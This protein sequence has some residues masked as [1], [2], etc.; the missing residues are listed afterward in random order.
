MTYPAFE[1]GE[2]ISFEYVWKREY[3]AGQRHGLKARPCAVVV[4]VADA[5]GDRRIYVA[6]ITH[7]ELSES[8]AGVVIPKSIKRALGLDDAPS[9]IIVNELN[10]TLLPSPEIRKTPQGKW[11]YGFLPEPFF[12][13]VYDA[14]MAHDR[15]RRLSVQDR[16]E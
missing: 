1:V 14:I 8:S 7:V 12:A 13:A 9:W 10:K 5:S 2:V 6:P 3:D 16:D 4:A 11:S 15:G